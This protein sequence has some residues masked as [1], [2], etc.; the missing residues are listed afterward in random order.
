DIFGQ[1]K[2]PEGWAGS[3]DRTTQVMIDVRMTEEL[4]LEGLAREIVRQVQ[5]LRRRSELQME[6]RIVLSLQTDSPDLAK[7][8]EKHRDYICRE[9]LAVEF[10]TRPL[11]KGAHRAEVKI[12]GHALTIELRRAAS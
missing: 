11:G 2:A 7:A 3:A 6:D 8:I 1:W 9:T 5:E 12:E 10:T 4:K